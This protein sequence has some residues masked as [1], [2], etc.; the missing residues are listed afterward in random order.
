[1]ASYLDQFD[2]DVL[3]PEAPLAD[4]REGACPDLVAHF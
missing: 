1:M 3:P 4:G 2:R